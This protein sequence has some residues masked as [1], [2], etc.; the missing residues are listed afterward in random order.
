VT[1]LPLEDIRVLITR[2]AHQAEDLAVPLRALGAEVI[3]LPVIAIA[4]PSDSEPLRLAAQNA[5]T[6]DWIIFTSANAIDAFAAQLKRPPGNLQARIATVG[7]AT[8][9]AAL[10]K[11][12]AVHLTPDHYVAE[13]LLEAFSDHNISGLRVLIPSAAVT[14][15]LIPGKLRD[16]GAQV[17]VVE[18]YRNVRPSDARERASAIFQEPYPDWVLFAS[19]SA[20]DNLVELVGADQLRRTKIASIGPMTSAS[21]RKHGLN[22]RAEAEPHTSDGLIRAI[23]AAVASCKKT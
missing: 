4:S 18:A 7:A 17:D 13:S 5:Q 21:I 23:C 16:R 14:R 1:D 20:V 9:D 22:V 11:G 2:A 10:A 19:S 6:Y 3:L 8:R 12:F 15:D